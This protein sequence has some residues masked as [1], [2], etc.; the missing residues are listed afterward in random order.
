MPWHGTSKYLMHLW[1]PSVTNSARGSMSKLLQQPAV[2]SSFQLNTLWYM[3]SRLSL[4][5]YLRN[6]PKDWGRTFPEKNKERVLKVRENHPMGICVDQHSADT[7]LSLLPGPWCEL[8]CSAKHS[9]MMEWGF[10]V[11]DLKYTPSL[12]CFVLFCF[13]LFCFFCFVLF[14]F[15]L[16]FLF[17]FVL[18]CFVFFPHRSSESNITSTISLLLHGPAGRPAQA[19]SPERSLQPYKVKSAFCSQ[20]MGTRREGC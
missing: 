9:A 1:C 14:C 19:S 18:F 4:S 20:I 2:T 7:P 8:L 6:Y 17:C 3:W 5:A 10:Q 13:V 16:F 12:V 15:V 11:Q